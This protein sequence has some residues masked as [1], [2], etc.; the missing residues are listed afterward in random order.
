MK[1]RVEKNRKP[2]EFSNKKLSR[3]EFEEIIIRAYPDAKQM[4]SAGISIPR[5]LV[6]AAT[7]WWIYE[8]PETDEMEEIRRNF[9]HLEEYGYFDYRKGEEDE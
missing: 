1:I 9:K 4:I 3:E 8:T 2:I 6:T 5:I 7:Q